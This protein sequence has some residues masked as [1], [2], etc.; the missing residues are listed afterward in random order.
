VR[1]VDIAVVA[2]ILR[3]VVMFGTEDRAVEGW[4]RELTEECRTV[5]KSTD[6]LETGRTYILASSILLQS[7]CHGY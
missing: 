5:S 2:C 7:G 3:L 1:E 4:M 6:T